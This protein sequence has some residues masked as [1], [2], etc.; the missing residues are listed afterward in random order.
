MAYAKVDLNGD[1]IEFPCIS[2]DDENSIYVEV[3]DY[4]L[5][6]EKFKWYQS[7]WYDSVQ[8]EDDKYYAVYRIDNRKFTDAKEK[9]EVFKFFIEASRGKNQKRY[10]DGGITKEVYDANLA[11]LENIDVNDPASDDDLEKLTFN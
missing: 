4:K 7:I 3:D 9:K 11:I 10:D 8:R 1:V 2:I 6:P 5:K